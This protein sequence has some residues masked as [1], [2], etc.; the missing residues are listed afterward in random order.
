LLRLKRGSQEIPSEDKMETKFVLGSELP[1]LLRNS[2]DNSL[3]IRIAVAFLKNGGFEQIEDNIDKA[4][5]KGKKVDFVI[6]AYPVF[7]ITDPSAL[8]KLKALEKKYPNNMNVG[9]FDTGDFHPKLFIF[10]CM[11]SNKAIIGSSNLT[12]G[13]VGSNIEAN[14]FLERQPNDELIKSITQFFDNEIMGGSNNLSQEFIDVYTKNFDLNRNPTSNS[15]IWPVLLP[16]YIKKWEN[17]PNPKRTLSKE[18]KASLRNK[19]AQIAPETWLMAHYFN[20]AKEYRCS[21]L[22][23]KN[24]K[25]RVHNQASWKRKRRIK[26]ESFD[27][28]RLYIDQITPLG[29]S[30]VLFD[31]KHNLSKYSQGWVYSKDKKNNIDGIVV[32]WYK[33]SIDNNFPSKKR[34]FIFTRKKLNTNKL[35]AGIDVY[36][37]ENKVDP[38]GDNKYIKPRAR[39]HGKLIKV[40]KKF[41]DFKSEL[42][43]KQR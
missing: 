27:G 24:T 20:L 36:L 25:A 12:S 7:H 26:L 11:N 23:V 17:Y 29:E 28:Y 38:I 19:I 43:L 6:G 15:L 21:A 4:L 13:G 41:G 18:E 14:I 42:P 33:S 9:I 8:S 40:V 30:R 31:K 35:K 1:E 32:L 3:Y 22:Q 5:A 10:Q 16:K 34:P 37:I 2:I 39:A